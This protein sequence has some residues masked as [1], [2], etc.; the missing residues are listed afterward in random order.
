MPP[1]LALVLWFFLLVGLL[2]FDPAKEQRSSLA[3]WVPLAWMFIL[4]SRLPSQWL[5]AGMESASQALEEGNA[6]D[7]TILSVLM[8]LA[9]GILLSRPFRWADFFV[10]NFFLVVFLLFALMS[11]FWSDFPLVAM[12]RWFRDIGG[13]IVILVVLSDPRPFEAF[14][15]ILRRLAYLLMPLSVVLNKYYPQISKQ[16]D[17][18][19]GAAMFMGPTTSKNMLGIACLV[20]GIFFFWDTL[21]RWPDRRERRT[22][23]II[24]LNTL[25]L[26]MT[27]WQLSL[28]DS[29]TSR[30]CL[31]LGC[32][33]I[34]AAHTKAIKRHP[35]FL[36]ILI[37]VC[38]C[39]Y[40]ILEFA[41]G[42]DLN[43]VMAEAV[44]RNPT[45]TG[46]TDLW[47]LLLSMH[48]NPI[49]G[50]GYD[51]F[52]LGP[53]LQW[54]WR[55]FYLINE[56]HNGY[57]DIYLTLG[58]VGLFLLG[59]FLIVSYGTICKRFK[60]SSSLGSLNLALWTV[61]LFYN[62]T[63]AAFKASHLMWLTFLLGAVV[64][65]ERA[66]GRVMTPEKPARARL[67]TIPL[68]VGSLRR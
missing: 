17:P 16:Y 58:L 60:L 14:R 66:I 62:V 23:R 32:L 45:L 26:G 21:A 30:I 20:S 6:L 57:L 56:A 7:R 36:L 13:Y 54:V 52:W 40:M 38:L 41:L 44:G 35:R 47:K 5:G 1:S 46:R 48:T 18:W 15:T 31:V 64:V 33:V 3:L 63:E 25:F 55:K 50:T 39:L 37:P 34:A 2:R 9:I 51:S 65:P 24:V 22:K 8:V 12:K 49:L 67:S 42:M 61:L 19:S 29:A 27:L 53:R 68:E 10:R 28:A 11:I 43:A 59:G 4:A